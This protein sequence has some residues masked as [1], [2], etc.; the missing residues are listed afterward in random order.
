MSNN[1]G[2]AFSQKKAN[3][4]ERHLRNISKQICHIL[5]DELTP[6][7][8]EIAKELEEG[9]FVKKRFVKDNDVGPEENIFEFYE[10]FD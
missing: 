6:V 3:R 10:I 7:E 5:S 2:N 9:G 4:Q 8:L 1:K